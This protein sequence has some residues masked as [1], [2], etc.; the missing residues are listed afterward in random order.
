MSTIRLIAA[1]VLFLLGAV[2]IGQ[3]IGLIAGSAMTGSMFWAV[4]GAILVVV[5]AWLAF[6][7]L[8]AGREPAADEAE[9]SPSEP[10]R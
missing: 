2:W 1:V 9:A 5:A 10:P 4:V 7:G 3:G 8:R 6:T